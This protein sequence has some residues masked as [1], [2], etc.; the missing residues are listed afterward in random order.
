MEQV[1]GAE[2]LTKDELAQVRVGICPK[3]G[4]DL[5]LHGKIDADPNEF[6]MLYNEASNEWENGEDVELIYTYMGVQCQ[7]LGCTVEYDVSI[8][9]PEE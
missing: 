1:V 3:C 6:A 7:G 8:V 2:Q 4:G 9:R 5:W